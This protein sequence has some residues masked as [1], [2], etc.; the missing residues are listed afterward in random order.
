MG[1]AGER[2]LFDADGDLL[3]RL[4]DTTLAK[5][6]PPA[7]GTSWTFSKPITA[8]AQDAQ[9]A[10]DEPEVIKEV[11][12][13]VSSKHLMLVSPVFQ[14]MFKYSF[15]EGETLRS[16]GHAEVSLPD[17]DATAMEIA[18][19]IIHGRVRRVPR[20]VT[21]DTMAALSILVDK[22]Q[23]HEVVELW[24]ELWVAHLKPSIPKYHCKS[25]YKW[26]SVAWVFK[27][28]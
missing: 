25:V 27:L 16:T 20:K 3:L 4:T 1:M 13:L 7:T 5:N 2:L 28:S 12:M 15:V 18:L 24:V 8:P 11:G 10:D 26:L 21:L 22:Y 14:A 17:D 6:V 9:S 23:M 19:N